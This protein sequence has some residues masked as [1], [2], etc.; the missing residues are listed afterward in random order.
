MNQRG[1]PFN[2][3]HATHADLRPSVYSYSPGVYPIVGLRNTLAD[4]DSDPYLYEASRNDLIS[5]FKD[6]VISL[7]PP[8]ALNVSSSQN[9]SFASN[10]CSSPFTPL[11]AL[12]SSPSAIWAAVNSSVSPVHRYGARSISRSAARKEV[13]A[14]RTAAKTPE[15]KIPSLAAYKSAQERKRLHETPSSSG[16]HS[17]LSSPALSALS[18][19]P[20]SPCN[21]IVGSVQ[22]SPATRATAA[23]QPSPAAVLTAPPPRNTL[24]SADKR[25]MREALGLRYDTR[26][27]RLDH[28]SALRRTSSPTVSTRVSGPRK[29]LARHSDCDRSL[30][31]P[32]RKKRKSEGGESKQKECPMDVSTVTQS[33]ES[34]VVPQRTFPLH[35]PIHS[36]F[37]LFYRRFAVVSYREE[38]T[39][40][41]ATTKGLSDTTFNPPRDD[42]DLYTPRFVKGRGTTKVG[43]CPC[44][45]E[46]QSRGGE[47]KKLW[48]STKFSAFNYHMQYAHGISALTGRPFS[49]PVAFRTIQRTTVGKHE[50][51]QMMQGKC[52]KCKKWV[53]VEGVKDVPTKVKE[54]YW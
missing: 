40:K 14:I 52:H 17:M 12:F 53:A 47:E 48:L 13:D 38:Y 3:F 21:P 16:P 33:N 27:R 11:Q 7:T 42:F 31:L 2:S 6:P 28:P 54:I 50:K 23:E 37:P 41:Y 46:N 20:T 24:N 49:P 4:W 34:A 43:L 26:A 9:S 30:V 25:A 15:K 32:A 18:S 22:G 44:C 51:A 35:V 5:P 29:R 36:R 39:R 19:M 45:M 8:L 1:V 10:S